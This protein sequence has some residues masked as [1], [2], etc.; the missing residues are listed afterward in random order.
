MCVVVTEQYNVTVN[1]EK[2]TGTEKYLTL[3]TRCRINRCCCNRVPMQFLADQSAQIAAPPSN[4][5]H[6]SA[7]G[8]V[9]YTKICTHSQKL[10]LKMGEF[11]ARNMLGCFKKINK[12]KKLLHLV[13]CLR[14]STSDTRHTNVKIE[15]RLRI[16][17]RSRNVMVKST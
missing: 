13:G 15:R 11:V 10:P 3:Y 5:W 8:A 6:R 12:L 2:L 9:Q 14:H 4:R 17:C 16:V 1:S 7:A